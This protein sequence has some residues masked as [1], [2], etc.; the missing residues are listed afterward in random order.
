MCIKFDKIVGF[1]KNYN[2]IRYLVLFGCLWYD[3]I[4]D[5]IKY[6]I[7]EKSDGTDS[8]NHNFARISIDSCNSLPI[9]KTLNFHNVNF[10][11]V[12]FQLYW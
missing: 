2:G 10:H 8:T 7:I 6:L 5:I 12:N 1:M 4:F 11:N 3:N 9:E